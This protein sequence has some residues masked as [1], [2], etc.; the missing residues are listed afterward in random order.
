MKNLNMKT[1]KMLEFALVFTFINHFTFCAQNNRSTIIENK[2]NAESAINYALLKNANDHNVIDLQYKIIQDSVSA[3]KI[4]ETILFRIYKKDNII[5]QQPYEIHHIKN[6][7]Y[8]SGTLPK[9]TLGGT[10]L[11]IIDDRNS[12]IIKITHGK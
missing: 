2:K 5:K 8:L 11:I 7:W 10:F 4:A 3:V 1:I 9:K 12:Q 6:Y